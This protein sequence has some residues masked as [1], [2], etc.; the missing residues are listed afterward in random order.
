MSSL[1]HAPNADF[2]HVADEVRKLSWARFLVRRM[3][4][5]NKRLI[6]R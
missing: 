5:R 6:E 3:I 1:P 2:Q 4:K